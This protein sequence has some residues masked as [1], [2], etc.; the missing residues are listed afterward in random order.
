[1]TSPISHF[2]DAAGVRIHAQLDGADCPGHPVVM[3]HGFTGSTE[4]MAGVAAT[5]AA[6]RPVA[7]IDLVGH[8]RSDAPA[9]TGA[10]RMEA[11]IDQ[12]VA[13]LDA[14]GLREPHLLGS[15]MGARAALSFCVAHPQRAASALLIAAS[16]GLESAGEREARVRTDEARSQ[17]ILRNGLGAFVDEWMALP[18]FASQKRLGAG[19]L[20]AA[21]AQRLR[22]RPEGLA[23]SLR[24]MGT[25]AMPPLHAR[26]REFRR[27]VC[28]AVGAEDE[29]FAALAAQMA[30]RLPDAR[31]AIVPAAGHAAHLENPGFFARLARDFFAGVDAPRARNDSRRSTGVCAP[32]KPPLEPTHGKETS[33]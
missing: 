9:N 33:P 22:C 11:C 24:G 32:S 26:L 13:V 19:A 3:L 4:S 5:L 18:L 27:P 12:L 23:G 17:R 30:R 6:E 2:V 25:G 16:P 1:V 15:S 21:R 10:Y 28:L 29:K 20:K 8:G 31:L 14:L 7:R